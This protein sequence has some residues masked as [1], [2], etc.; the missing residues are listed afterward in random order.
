MKELQE[1]FPLRQEIE[2]TVTA[3]NKRV[4]EEVKFMPLKVL[5]N[6]CH[7]LYRGV[8]AHGLYKLGFFTETDVK[9]Y[10]KTLSYE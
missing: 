2:N 5:L 7:P 9:E 3:F 6:N 4:K 10:T 8:Y 1:S